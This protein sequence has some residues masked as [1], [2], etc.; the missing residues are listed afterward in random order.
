VYVGSQGLEQLLELMAND[1]DTRP[2]VV[3]SRDRL[4]IVMGLLASQVGVLVS[5]SAEAPVSRI[6]ASWTCG[7]QQC[8]RMRTRP[9]QLAARLRLA[10][11]C[12][13]RPRSG[14]LWAPYQCLMPACSARE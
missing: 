11:Q 5:W 6:R 7:L 9:A 1:G 12:C 10:C 4:D 8:M 13:T 3:T 2:L 14:A